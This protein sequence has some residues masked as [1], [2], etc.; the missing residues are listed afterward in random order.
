MGLQRVGSLG[1]Q[2]RY[3][4]F[5]HTKDF[6]FE[7]PAFLGLCTR[8]LASRPMGVSPAGETDKRVTSSK[9]ACL[10]LI[11]KTISKDE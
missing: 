6:A 3:H 8:S 7:T 11:N 4:S 2:A 10:F 1:R 9:E 5:M